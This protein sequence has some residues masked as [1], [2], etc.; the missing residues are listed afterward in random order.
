MT[1]RIRVLLLL[2]AISS[3]SAFGF[4][5]RPVG[6]LRFEDRSNCDISRMATD[7]TS[8][9]VVCSYAR[10]F[11]G[12]YGQI[13][14]AEGVVGPAFLISAEQNP[15]LV[16][17]NGAS[18]VVAET[19]GDGVYTA[20]IS[21]GG[22]MSEWRHIIEGKMSAIAIAHNGE[23]TL[24]VTQKE[25]A[26]EVAFLD[27]NGNLAGTAA[28]VLPLGYPVG[29][30]ALG[31]GFAFV[32]VAEQSTSI[33]VTRLDAFGSQRG[34]TTI[35]GPFDRHH[36]VVAGTGDRLLLVGTDDPI[37]G[38]GSVKTAIV[39]VA[40]NVVRPFGEILRGAGSH[41]TI[42]TIAV[43]WTGRDFLATTRAYAD[44]FESNAFRIDADGNLAVAPQILSPVER[45][46]AIVALPDRAVIGFAKRG[47]SV[48]DPGSSIAFIRD[49]SVALD[50]PLMEIGRRIDPHDNYALGAM[51]GEYLAAWIEN[52][53]ST[54]TVRVS[55]IDR[56]G[57]YLD[58]AGIVLA[59]TTVRGIYAPPFS[60]AVAADGKNWLV[61]WANGGVRA[62]RLSSDGRVLDA[63]PLDL[64]A[65]DSVGLAWGNNSYAVAVANVVTWSAFTLDSAGSLGPRRT[66]AQGVAGDVRG[67]GQIA[68]R[69]AGVSFDGERFLAVAMEDYTGCDPIMPA[70]GTASYLAAVRLDASAT[71][72]DAVQHKWLHIT[73]GLTVA[74]GNGAHL[75]LTRTIVTQ[76]NSYNV[77]S[78]VTAMLVDGSAPPVISPRLVVGRGDSPAAAWSGSDFVTTWI[79][80]NRRLQLVRITEAGVVDGPHAMTNDYAELA[81]HPAVAIDPRTPALVGY[82]SRHVATDSVAR[83]A[84]AFP[85]EFDS[86]EPVPQPPAGVTATRIGTGVRV[87]WSP[88]AHAFG[89]DVELLLA[90][91]SH[92]RIATASAANVVDVPLD[93]HGDAVRVRAWNA[94]G[95]SAPSPDA[96]ITGGRIR[97]VRK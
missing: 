69:N 70:C 47:T 78:L 86:Q 42:D 2:V 97:N 94:S 4:R 96:W 74:G 87:R 5:G 20:T 45:P 65:G 84:L 32:A 59:R 73:D 34:T 13:V 83:V 29:A 7:G 50:G 55:R 77:E 53:G 31:N 11:G 3:T 8:A 39:D 85:V 46:T 49:R 48:T 91:G 63:Q 51:N 79:D 54:S 89:F 6:D 75:I 40:G 9:L 27:Q 22:A 25:S 58:G 24:L 80:G 28:T 38:A 62:T 30:L 43:A 15:P 76:P 12:T 52:H 61:A 1:T 26:R 95:I 16:A 71:P 64:G 10:D 60:V 68:Y 66:I 33:A 18:Y 67:S 72:L 81:F 17:W 35:D 21:R 44:T 14:S 41:Y 56:N 36:F 82:L 92:R 93:L 88:V 37:T 90:D 23:R 19:R 57:A